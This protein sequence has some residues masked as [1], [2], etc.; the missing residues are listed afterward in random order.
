ML[1]LG[2]GQL[3]DWWATVHSKTCQRGVAD[4]Q[5]DG[6]IWLAAS[7]EGTIYYGI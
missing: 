5:M 6:V 7:Q 1:A 2:V 3:L 4:Q